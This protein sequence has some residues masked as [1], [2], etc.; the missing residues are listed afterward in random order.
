MDYLVVYHSEDNDGL[1]S[2]AI[3]VKWLKD[4]KKA[5]AHS[6]K[7]AGV[8]YNL[9]NTMQA[10]GQL[11]T[12]SE[13]YDHIVFT[14]ISLNDPQMMLDLFVKNYH[15]EFTWIDHHKPV[16]DFS[17]TNELGK[18]PGLRDTKH[19]ALYNAWKY[20]Y[21]EKPMPELFKILSA[22]DSWTFEQEGIDK[23]FAT[24]VNQ[25][26]TNHFELNP[27]DIIYFVEKLINNPEKYSN[28]EAIEQ[29]RNAGAVY[30]KSIK[31][32]YKRTMETSG[33][34][35][36]TLGDT[37]RTLGVMFS[38]GQT[39]SQY[40]EC[41]KRKCENV[42]VF[43]RNPN[44]VWTVSLYNTD[45]DDTFHCG[46]YCKEKHHGGGHKGAAGCQLTEEE[47]VAML[48]NKVF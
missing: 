44:G 35:S 14:D 48:K 19:S 8:N 29:Y 34:F 12:F 9:L 40:F 37:H 13:N 39:S 36:W 32:Y 20:C 11:K 43:K 25:G 38:Q 28:K 46:E 41:C 22:Y 4:V 31:T 27:F 47:F 16:I 15:G 45:D 10:N 30:D 33:D 1:F 21:G 42:A 17:L 7:I 24:A 3:V 18:V 26:V 2:M 6:I 23:Q 5:P